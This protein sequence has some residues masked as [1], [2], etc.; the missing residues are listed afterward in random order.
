MT[1]TQDEQNVQ[2]S[3][4]QA[5][6]T[7]PVVDE[8]NAQTSG[9]Q[10]QNTDA[11]PVTDGS[12]AS[13]SGDSN[14]EISS[15]QTNPSTNEPTSEQAQNTTP[16]TKST[17]LIDDGKKAGANLL[18]TGV[19]KVKWIWEAG[20][21]WVKSAASQWVESVKDTFEQGKE[22]LKE[23]GQNTI[24]WIKWMWQD[25][26]EGFWN[27]F[28]EATS[29]KWVLEWSK[30]VIQG[31]VTTTT[32]LVGNAT[33]NAMDAGQSVVTWTIWATS[34]IATWAGNVVKD[35]INNV[36]WAVLP[37]QAAQKVS[38]FQ[39]KVSTTAQNLGT[40]AKDTLQE[41]WQ[42]AKWFFSG[43]RDNFKSGFSSKD[44]KKVM[45]E[46][47]APLDTTQ[48]PANPEVA[49]PT[50]QVQQP[51]APEVAQPA[52]PEVAQ[53]TPQVQQPTEVQPGDIQ[54]PTNPA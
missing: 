5:Q 22:T 10:A 16:E 6:G 42:K 40:Q 28:S 45:D 37:E 49:Q 26:K 46:A 38:D 19:E 54:Q 1:Q 44:A 36:A 29:G 53:P 34:N 14:T 32:N 51:V 41:T 35:S 39:N 7:N 43:L 30:A 9:T 4:S 47:N 23:T 24:E 12:Q 21:E 25:L 18:G 13:T 17:S 20:V 31:T 11:N 3:G 50:P 2:T 15:S 8:Q 48:Q 27:T 33:T 52:N